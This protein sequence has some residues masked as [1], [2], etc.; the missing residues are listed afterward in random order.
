MLEYLFS[1]LEHKSGFIENSKMFDVVPSNYW[2]RIKKKKK[3]ILI[4]YNYCRLRVHHNAFC[5]SAIKT[6][7]FFFS[8]SFSRIVRAIIHFVLNW[9][10]INQRKLI[11]SSSYYALRSYASSV[12]LSTS[13]NWYGCHHDGFFSLWN[14]IHAKNTRCHRFM[15]DLF[16]PAYM[17]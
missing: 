8:L 5:W 12:K 3:S 6:G 13:F 4:N 2:N 7:C 16:I 9:A 15:A 11:Q 17:G 10:E 1:V 14:R